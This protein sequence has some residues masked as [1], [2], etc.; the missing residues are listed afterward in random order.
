MKLIR[1]KFDEYLNTIKQN[2]WDKKE[3]KLG[4]SQQWVYIIKQ[5]R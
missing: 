4:W 2:T 5:N 1:I 3:G